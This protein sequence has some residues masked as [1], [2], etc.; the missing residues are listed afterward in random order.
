[1]SVEFRELLSDD[2]TDRLVRTNRLS[3]TNRTSH[4]YIKAL[5]KPEGA[6]PPVYFIGH[7]L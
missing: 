7:C 1:M 6:F 5:L 3:K 4:S 2:S